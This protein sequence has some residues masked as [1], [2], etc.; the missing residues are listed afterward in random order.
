MFASTSVGDLGS[1]TFQTSYLTFSSSLVE[2]RCALLSVSAICIS[3]PLLQAQTSVTAIAF[4]ELQPLRSTQLTVLHN[5]PQGF[6]VCLNQDL[7][8]IE[9][10]LKRRRQL[11]PVLFQFGC[12]WPQWQWGLLMRMPLNGHPEK[13]KLQDHPERRHIESHSFFEKHKT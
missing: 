1:F 7:S 13:R 10:S 9:L 8:S 4:F 3:L 2:R 11:I 5:R 6:V 12:C